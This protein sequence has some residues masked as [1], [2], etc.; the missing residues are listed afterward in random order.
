MRGSA[1]VCTGPPTI[2]AYDR[3]LCLPLP[4]GCHAVCYADDT[5][6]VATGARW[7]DATA[8]AEIAVAQV[9]R[10]ITD[11]G[12]KV[13]ANKTEAMFCYNRASGKPPYVPILRSVRR[14]SW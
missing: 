7:G 6:V 3:I 11:M 14:K 13:A 12:M 9:M 5:L 1:V 2:L 8:R 10:N 4:R